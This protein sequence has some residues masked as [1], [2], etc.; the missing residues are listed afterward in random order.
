[1]TDVRRFGTVLLTISGLLLIAGAFWVSTGFYTID[2]AVYVFGADTFLKTQGFFLE[3]G[4]EEF[5]SRD[6]RWIDLLVHRT[7]G[8][9]AQYPAGSAVVGAGLI[10][11]LDLR[12]ILLFHALCVAGSAFVTRA[13]ALKLFKDEKIALAAALLFL[14]GTFISEYAYGLWPHAVSVLTVAGSF[15]WFLHA[16]DRAGGALRAAAISGLILGAGLLFRLDNLFLLPVIGLLTVSLAARP[17]Q[18]FLGGALGL[19]PALALLSLSN[20]IKFGTL[21]PISYGHAG[22]DVGLGGYVLF[23]GAAAALFAA[24]VVVR[25]TGL[26]I[27][28]IWAIAAL[29]IAIAVAA[30]FVP[31]VQRLLTRLYHGFVALF[32]DAKTIVDP[33]GGVQRAADGTLRFWGLPKK[34]LGQSL[35]WLGVVLLLVFSPW[36]KHRRAIAITLAMV[37]LWSFPFVMRAWHGG[38]SLNMRYLMPLLPALSALCA[39]LIWQLASHIRGSVWILIATAAAGVA[40]GLGWA[41]FSPSGISGTH[42]ILSTFVLFAVAL[43]ALVAGLPRFSAG[44]VGGLSLGTTG[45]GI[46]LALFLSA[47]DLW[48]SQL[49]RIDVLTDT[50]QGFA[51]KV[52][53]YLHPF[54]SALH[55][56]NQMVAVPHWRNGGP[57]ADFVGK[58]ILQ[59]YRVLMPVEMAEKF[60]AANP[61]YQLGDE[62][63]QPLLM[64]E[65]LTK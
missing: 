53:V 31:E 63:A 51:G 7:E 34:A 59:G 62:I 18:I 24:L 48:I 46:G 64:R 44:P 41:V 65:I 9:T 8:L 32:I 57:D 61:D 17:V 40:I 5:G 37:A 21:N 30:A 23:A 28:P 58:G 27:K 3:N 43:T 50:S 1:M 14:F 25:V 42:Q 16:M 2:E 19:L 15:L 26:R 22:G 55:D 47:S 13:L 12:G 29:A 33:R 38:L 60:V 36:G 10:S 54:R 11:V 52:I 20:Q 56:P 45:L 6:L 49:R 35:P 39:A 4:Y